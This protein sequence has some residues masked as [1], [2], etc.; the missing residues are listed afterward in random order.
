MWARKQAKEY[1]YYEDDYEE[2]LTDEMIEAGWYFNATY[3]CED[4]GLRVQ[5]VTIDAELE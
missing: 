1:A 3:S 4:D 5:E 2:S